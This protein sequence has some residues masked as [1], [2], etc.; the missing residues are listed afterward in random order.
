MIYIKKED[1][2][3]GIKKQKNKNP[4]KENKKSMKILNK[5]AESVSFHQNEPLD[6]ETTFSSG[7]HP[8]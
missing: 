7:N 1:N 8:I 3:N 4:K 5:H 2:I 6:A